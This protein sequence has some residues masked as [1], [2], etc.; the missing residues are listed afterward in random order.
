MITIHSTFGFL[1]PV[2]FWNQNKVFS[3]NRNSISSS[4]TTTTTTLSS[5]NDNDFTMPSPET[6]ISDIPKDKRGIGV[7]IDLGTTN[8]AIG[9]LN[10]EGIPYLIQMDGKSTIPSVVTLQSST[11]ED[12]S[13][14]VYI[15]EK[16]H[17]PLLGDDNESFTYR[18]VK[19][20]IGMGTE[21][22]E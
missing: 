6:L 11:K 15:G 4:T 1:I 8:S 21:V 9:M 17:D 10:E 12:H 18:H 16:E 22:G 14:Q 7:G 19:R 3:V 20:V 2:S 13:Y 5:T